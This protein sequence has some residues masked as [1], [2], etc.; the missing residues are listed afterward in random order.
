MTGDPCVTFKLKN[1]NLFSKS[2]YSFLKDITIRFHKIIGNKKEEC[3]TNLQIF[4]NLDSADIF[5]ETF[6]NITLIDFKNTD[7][8]AQRPK[9]F[10]SN[11]A[12]CNDSV[13]HIN[14]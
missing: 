6:E 10:C 12:K 8:K 2:L 5:K 11:D 9:K 7:E 14:V 4:K 1:H 13:D 3:G